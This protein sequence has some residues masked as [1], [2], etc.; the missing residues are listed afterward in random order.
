MKV[1]ILWG[2]II[3]LSL[4]CIILRRRVRWISSLLLTAAITFFSL[5]TPEGKVLVEFSWLHITL[6]A[7]ENGLFKSG[8][9]IF[10]QLFSKILITSKIPLPGKAG[11]FIKTVFAIYEKLTAEK[12]PQD[13]KKLKGIIPA[14][15][16]KLLTIWNDEKL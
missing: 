11:T 3:A 16:E 12:L 4:I 13:R 7:L 1:I 15:D 8:I 14:I 5:L 9:L 10:L 6:G 2:I